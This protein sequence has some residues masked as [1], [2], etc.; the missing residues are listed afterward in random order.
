MSEPLKKFL[1]REFKGD[2]LKQFLEV[3]TEGGASEVEDLYDLTEEDYKSLG[4]KVIPMRKIISAVKVSLN[5]PHNIFRNI[6]RRRQMS[7]R[8]IQSQLLSSEKSTQSFLLIKRAWTCPAGLRTQAWCSLSTQAS[9]RPALWG[10]KMCAK[11]WL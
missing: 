7:I 6:K 2:T 11:T 9:D 8:P 1:E 5:L 3:L 10:H 4:I